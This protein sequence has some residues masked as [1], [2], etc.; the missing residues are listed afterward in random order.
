VATFQTYY[1]DP[2][3]GDSGRDGI[4]ITSLL[5]M[6]FYQTEI[7]AVLPRVAYVTWIEVYLFVYLGIIAQSCICFVLVITQFR[8]NGPYDKLIA[9]IKKHEES[10]SG[11]ETARLMAEHDEEKVAEISALL[12]KEED[13]TDEKYRAVWLD[14]AHRKWIPIFTVVFNV[15]AF[16]ALLNPWALRM[17]ED[18]L[19]TDAEYDYGH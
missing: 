11:E 17:P 18:G 16:S 15:L 6:A 14:T 7:K 19:I 9:L 10:G 12:S 3:N 4:T 1:Q 2:S 8:D 13:D 5:A